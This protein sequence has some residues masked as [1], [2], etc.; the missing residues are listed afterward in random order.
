MN[1]DSPVNFYIHTTLF[2]F[3]L[4]LFPKIALAENMTITYNDTSLV[5]SQCF[6]NL[7]SYSNSNYSQFLIWYNPSDTSYY[8]Y[9]PSNS[10]TF[11]ARRN[12][13]NFTVSWST[14]TFRYVAINDCSSVNYDG[15]E[16][17]VGFNTYNDWSTSSP[18]VLYS[19]SNITIN[20]SYPIDITDGIDT[21]TCNVNDSCPYIPMYYWYNS[22]PPTPP[23]T[24]PLLTSFITITTDSLA[25]IC[26]FIT[27]SYIYL[28]IFVV[29]LLYFVIYLIRRLK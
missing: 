21:F 27:S 6:T 3:F 15:Y 8:V 5:N 22:T 11:F 14:G 16:G 12:Y 18:Y 24:T 7:L 17:S 25:Y 20:G 4:L 2:I 1:N 13:A 9:V 19:S 28:S 26:E 23:D 10:V 29:I